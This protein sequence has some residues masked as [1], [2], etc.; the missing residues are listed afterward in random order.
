MKPKFKIGEK[1][2]RD[3]EGCYGIVKEIQERADH[4]KYKFYYVVEWEKTSFF[5]RPYKFTERIN[6]ALL[7]KIYE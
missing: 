6:E 4:Y 7:D 1:V 5:G 2:V 3:F